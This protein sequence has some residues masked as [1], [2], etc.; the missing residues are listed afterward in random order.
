MRDAPEV[1]SL[2][3]FLVALEVHSGEPGPMHPFGV[4]GPMHDRVGIL[5]QVCVF[6]T[7]DEMRGSKTP[8]GLVHLDATQRT[9]LPPEKRHCKTS[10]LPPKESMQATGKGA[11]LGADPAANPNR[12]LA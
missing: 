8:V 6:L 10:A 3:P 12:E 2:T 7:G 11:T 9:F 5:L 1:V 4:A